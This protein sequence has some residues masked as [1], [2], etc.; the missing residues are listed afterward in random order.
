MFPQ[1][2]GYKLH[3]Y[4]LVC[5]FFPFD[6][7]LMNLQ[8]TFGQVQYLIH[9]NLF[10]CQGHHNVIYKLENNLLLLPLLQHYNSIAC[11]IMI[12]TTSPTSKNK[13]GATKQLCF[14]PFLMWKYNIIFPL[15]QMENYTSSETKVNHVY[16]LFC[17]SQ[18]LH[19]KLVTKKEGAQLKQTP[20]NLLDLHMICNSWG[21]TTTPNLSFLVTSIRLQT[22]RKLLYTHIACAHGLPQF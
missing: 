10:P 16:E 15:K 7:K 1:P 2:H 5:H 14:I 8:K 6:I 12:F 18:F 11:L 19:G 13:Y 17:H 4:V 20:C 21:S 22:P 3:C 9:I